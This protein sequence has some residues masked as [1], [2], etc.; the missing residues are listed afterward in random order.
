MWESMRQN[1]GRKTL[2]LVAAEFEIYVQQCREDRALESDE[3]EARQKKKVLGVAQ[4]NVKSKERADAGQ[5]WDWKYT[6][7]PCTMKGCSKQWYSP[8]DNRLFLFYHTKRPSGLQPLTTLCPSCARS[9]VEIAEERIKDR[10]SDAGAGPEWVEWCGQVQNDRRME[11]EYWM[12]AQERVV[13]E[14]GVSAVV[15]VRKEKVGGKE[16]ITGKER[17]KKSEILKGI[18]VVM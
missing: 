10:R 5:D 12:Q 8:F 11:E 2:G 16:G 6:P 18:C 4:S 13:R 15:A 1:A 9:D 3:L 7:R 14:K 17:K